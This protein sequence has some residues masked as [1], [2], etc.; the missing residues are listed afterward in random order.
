[1]QTIPMHDERRNPDERALRILAKSVYRELKTT[2]HSRQDIVGFASALLEMVTSE[3][4]DG[5]S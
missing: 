1:M 4:K 2:G 3:L 5:D